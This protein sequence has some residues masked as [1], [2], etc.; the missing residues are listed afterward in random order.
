M[1]RKGKKRLDG[2]NILGQDP[3]SA[4]GY[5]R[6]EFPVT[7]QLR[8]KRQRQTEVQRRQECRTNKNRPKQKRI[9]EKAGNKR[10]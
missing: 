7:R 9:K 6:N 5:R 2:K 1:T 8:Q 10:A 3:T 4:A